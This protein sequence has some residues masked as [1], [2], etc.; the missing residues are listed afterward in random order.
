MFLTSPIK[1]INKIKGQHKQDE[2][3][4]LVSFVTG[5][6]DPVSQASLTACYPFFIHIILSLAENIHRF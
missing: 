3:V 5:I 6:K 4:K 1:T 2:E